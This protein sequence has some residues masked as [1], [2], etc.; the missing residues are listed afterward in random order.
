MHREEPRDEI[1]ITTSE[2]V[3][4]TERYQNLNIS[5]EKV[6]ISNSSI[7]F[8]FYYVF[9]FTK[10]CFLYII[11]TSINLLGLKICDFS[12]RASPML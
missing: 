8:Q 3:N 5:L 6:K 9:L 10:Y 7:L 12:P 4:A 11:I 2:N 1:D